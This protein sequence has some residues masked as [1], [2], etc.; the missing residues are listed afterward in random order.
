[1]IL[2]IPFLIAVLLF[3]KDNLVSSWICIFMAETL[4]CSNWA[5]ISDMLMY[6]IVPTKRSTASA[7]QI[8]VMHLLGDASSPYIVG[9]ISNYYLKGSTVVLT[10]WT[11]LRNGLLLTP[12]VSAL[13]GIAF[14]IAAFYIVQDRRDAEDNI[15]SVNITDAFRM[16]DNYKL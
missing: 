6:I 14:L 16:S 5:L 8:F 13:G 9:L 7:I 2:S 1:V 11:S 12:A 10:E 4:L 15:Q 3:S